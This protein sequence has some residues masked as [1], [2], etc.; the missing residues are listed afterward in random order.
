MKKEKIDLRT[1]KPGDKL[2]SSHGAELEY[3]RPTTEREY[4]DHVVK[5]LDENLGMGTRTHDGFVFKNNRIPEIDHDIV[6][7]L[8]K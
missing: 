4:L 6:K 8:K 2:I 1:C 5:Y 7:I 3:V